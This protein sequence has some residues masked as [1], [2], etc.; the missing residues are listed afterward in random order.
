MALPKLPASKCWKATRTLWCQQY[1]EGAEFF[2]SDLKTLCSCCVQ[3][4]VS[5]YRAGIKRPA[6][7]IVG[8]Q[9]IRFAVLSNGES[10]KA[11]SEYITLARK[12][13]DAMT[14]H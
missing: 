8:S 4:K 5:A 12:I 11:S 13:Y 3:L 14:A 9:S 1:A 7:R 2:S 6:V 10:E